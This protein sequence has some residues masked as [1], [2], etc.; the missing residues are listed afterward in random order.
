MSASTVV[1]YP[2]PAGEILSPDYAVR[3]NGRPLAIYRAITQHH[4][5]K[6][7]FAYFD[8]AGTVEIEVT[9]PLSLANVEILPQIDGLTSS[10]DA[11]GALH[12]TVSRPFKIS[13]EPDGENSPLLLFG[14]PLEESVPKLGDA[15]VIYFGPGT[16]DAGRIS[17]TSNQTLYL[18]AG[19]VVKG[20]IEASGDNIT[21]RGRGILDG[22]DWPHYGGPT[23]FMLGLENCT[24]VIIRDIILRGAWGWT[25]VPCGCDR[26]TITNVKL[27]GSRVD[28]DDG[29]DP[30]NSSNIT[31]TECFLRTDDDCIAIKG[32][33]GYGNKSCENITITDC[34]F[35]TD[36]ANI[37]RIGYESDADAMR[38]ITA[39]NIDVLHFLGDYRPPET[40]W[41]TWVF[42]LQPSNNMPMSDL[43]FEN[44]RINAAGDDNNLIK[45]LP[46]RCEGMGREN[47][48]FVVTPY[49]QP[50]K[51]V[52]R[53]NFRNIS[54]SGKAGGKPGRIYVLGADAEHP[55]E[56]VTLQQITRF[57]ELASAKSPEVTVGTHVRNII[58][59]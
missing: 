3:V 17:L 38:N 33:R 15:N 45:I 36:R 56:D 51:Y 4:D 27:C 44:I 11:N 14:N 26:V 20:G 50:G 39:R 58:F 8:F 6:Y 25:I 35:W 53:C 42:Y 24:N 37:F 48:Q 16:H 43:L 46:M 9:S 31:I 23:Q 13:I 18:A 54:L 10:L 34:S 57:G 7:S 28:N 29:I 1:T 19:A 22:T 30:V 55:V 12:L 52:K 21:I 41:G 2:A 47:G 49:E 40:H 59:Q 5:K 32:L